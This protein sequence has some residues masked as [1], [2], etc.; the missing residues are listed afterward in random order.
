MSQKDLFGVRQK[1]TVGG[2]DYVYYS[3]KSLDTKGVGEI[4]RLPFSI[5]VLLEAAVRQYDGHSVTKEH[6]EQLANWTSQKNKTEVAFKPARIVLQD[7][8]GVPAVVDLA[9]LR[10]AMDRV[11]GDPKRI[12]PLIPVDLVIDHSVMVDEFGTEDALTYNM[13]REFER[14]EERYRLLR[15]ATDSLRQFPGRP[16]GHRDCPPG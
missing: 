6:I 4:S 7:F 1:L 11:G 10:S 5:K 16:S 12:N 14:N 8:T 3:L 9:A 2:K 13:D 15:W